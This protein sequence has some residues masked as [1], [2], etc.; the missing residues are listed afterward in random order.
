MAVRIQEV[1]GMLD[2]PRLARGSLPVTMH[3]LAPNFRP[4][5]VTRDLRSFW[6]G[7]YHEVRKELRLKYPRHAWPDDP[8]TAKAERGPR[9]RNS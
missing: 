8:F 9:R 6:A 4:Q 1:F 7:A 3:L 2:T 5:Q